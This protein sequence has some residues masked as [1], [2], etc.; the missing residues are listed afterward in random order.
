M[1]H[2]VFLLGDDEARRWQK[3]AVIPNSL[4]VKQSRFGKLGVGDTLWMFRIT[5]D[6]QDAFLCGRFE[7]GEI[8]RMGSGDLELRP[9]AGSPGA[10]RNLSLADADLKV[11]Y[12][13]C[14]GNVAGF[15][16]STWG[17]GSVELKGKKWS[18]F[19]SGWEINSK[20]AARLDFLWQ[21]AK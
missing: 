9:S 10:L 7:V 1:R 19:R 3:V 6:P 17:G 14:D 18:G 11:E 13:A 16:S 5:W 8:A 12:L 2:F 15:K 21:K 4:K 20:S